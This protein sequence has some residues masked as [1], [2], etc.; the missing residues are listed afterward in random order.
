[1]NNK[2]YIFL[3]LVVLSMFNIASP[4]LTFSFGIDNHPRRFYCLLKNQNSYSIYVERMFETGNTFEVSS[5]STTSQCRVLGC[6]RRFGHLGPPLSYFTKVLP[7]S[8]VGWQ[9]LLG[10]EYI[11]SNEWH[12]VKWHVCDRF[13]VNS[14]AWFSCVS[15]PIYLRYKT[16]TDASKSSKTF[17]LAQNVTNHIVALGVVV[18]PCTNLSDNVAFLYFNPG[19]RQEKVDLL[20]SIPNNLIISN[21]NMIV[22]N[23]IVSLLNNDIANGVNYVAPGECA[24]WQYPWKDITNALPKSIYNAIKKAD[25]VK[26]RWQYGELISDPLYLWIKKE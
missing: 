7:K 13:Q 19:F 22:T 5:F 2:L 14:Q 16:A 26:L 8:E 15:S 24:E 12:S 21:D 10:D 18:S 9:P 25:Y 6:F 4:S 11:S 17:L 1:M 23:S 3:L 20:S